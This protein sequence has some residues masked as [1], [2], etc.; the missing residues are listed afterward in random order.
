[1][2]SWLQTAGGG[3]W[4]DWLEAGLSLLYPENCQHCARESATAAQG[5][6]GEECRRQVRWI[7]PP[8]CERCGLPFAGDITVR[9]ECANCRE[10]DLQ[11]AW[12]RSAVSAQGM[13]LE[14]VHRY[15]YG[16]ALW[17]EPFLAELLTAAARP[18]LEEEPWDALVPVPLHPVRLR[19]REFNQAE[20]LARR[21]GEA[22]G[23]PVQSRW[24]QR[25]AR[26][27]TQTQLSRADRIDNVRRAFQVPE[28]IDLSGARIVLVDDVLTTGATTSACATA[29]RKAGADRVSVWTVAR[30][31]W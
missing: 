19:E 17:F 11:F 26:T 23:L 2:T 29:L 6:I 21:L 7:R 1:M 18:T 10:L 12:A 3:G 24:L 5:Y 8:F 9:F 22:A 14:V 30:G 27:H 15:K 31:L 4:R 25:I 28:R 20:R 13:I 16:R